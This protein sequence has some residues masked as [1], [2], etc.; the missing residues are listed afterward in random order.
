MDRVTGCSATQE[1]IIY[2]VSSAQ[3]IA[4]AKAG[5]VFTDGHAIM[6]L[7]EFYDDLGYLSEIDW[8]IMKEKYWRDTIEDP[9]RSRRRQAEFLVFRQFSWTLV[10]KIGVCNRTVER[11]VSHTVSV[12]SHKP[13]VNIEPSW[14]Y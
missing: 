14:Y 13:P 7:S 9:D 11:E 2:L 3:T 12:A 6:Q 4:A 8:N 1:E 5:F 10:E